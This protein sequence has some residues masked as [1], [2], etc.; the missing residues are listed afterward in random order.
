MLKRTELAIGRKY[1]YFRAPFMAI[2]AT[3]CLM[4]M[5]N[6][7]LSVARRVFPILIVG[8]LVTFYNKNIGMYGVTRDIDSILILMAGDQ[9]NETKDGDCEVRRLTKSFIKDQGINL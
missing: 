1:N 7:K 5:F 9:M 3:V 4:A 6:T 8:P 2:S